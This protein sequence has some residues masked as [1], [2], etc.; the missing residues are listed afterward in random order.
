MRVVAVHPALARVLH[1]QGAEHRLDGAVEPDA[2]RGGRGVQHVADPRLGMIGEDVRPRRRPRGEQRHQEQPGGHPPCV[3]RH[4][5][6]VGPRTPWNGVQVKI[7]GAMS[8][9]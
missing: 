9:R 5:G 8:S 2:H 1:P 3:S 6:W 4:W 7:F